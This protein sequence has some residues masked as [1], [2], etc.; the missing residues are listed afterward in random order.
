MTGDGIKVLECLFNTIW[1]LFS[2]WHIPGTR[3]TPAAAFLF[4]LCAS[5]G[6]KFLGRVIG[7]GVDLEES[8]AASRQISGAVRA[9]RIMNGPIKNVFYGGG[10]V[11]GER[12]QI[13]GG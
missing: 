4:F 11:V 3:V 7:I 8:V 6:L 9:H 12:K 1:Q 5:I 10:P 2:S 13:G